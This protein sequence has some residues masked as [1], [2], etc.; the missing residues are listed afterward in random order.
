VRVRREAHHD[1]RP[2]VHAT[3]ASVCSATLQ[4]RAEQA[5]TLLAHP[6]T[7][8]EHAVD[9]QDRVEPNLPEPDFHVHAT[10]AAVVLGP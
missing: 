9:A 2:R 1:K 3:V 7:G 4:R 10:F 6:P 5:A 8:D